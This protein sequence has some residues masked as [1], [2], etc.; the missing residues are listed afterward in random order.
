M[1][2]HLAAASI[3]LAGCTTFAPTPAPTSL[4]FPP[5]PS[6]RWTMATAPTTGRI[7]ICTDEAG[8]DALAK[9][10]I[11]LDAFESAWERLEERRR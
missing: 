11:Q 6:I 7:V 5:R 8:G 4:P 3:L 9:Y 2:L 1:M 10:L